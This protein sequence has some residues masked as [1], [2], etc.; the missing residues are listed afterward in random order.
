MPDE[1]GHQFMVQTCYTHMEPSDQQKRLPQPPL[2]LALSEGHEVIALPAPSDI[3]VAAMDLRQA[4]EER[5]SVRRYADTP[6]TLDE[7]SYLL[8]CTLGVRRRDSSYTLRNVPSAGA[9][10]ALETWLLINRVQGLKPGLYRFMAL[11]HQLAVMDLSPDIAEQVT[12]GCLGQEFVQTG[13]VTW[14]WVAVPYRMSWRYGQR[15]YR[16]LH[17]DAGHVCQNLYLSAAS[18]GCG[19]CAIAAFI[20]EQMN[21]LL[22]LDG[23]EQFVIYIAA[24]GKK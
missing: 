3:Q 12:A 23:I 6:L 11:E 16:Y 20:D 4:I 13:A 8:W 2:Q 15:G 7:L 24:L 18:V 14:I 17:L 21:G 9:R 5:V 10:H 1:I 22:G 19:V